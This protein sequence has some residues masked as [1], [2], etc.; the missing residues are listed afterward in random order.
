[1]SQKLAQQP[2]PSHPSTK[3]PEMHVLPAVRFDRVDVVWIVLAAAPEPDPD[4]EKE[5]APVHARGLQP[6]D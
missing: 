2:T 5:T 4:A 1:M 3:R 6:I